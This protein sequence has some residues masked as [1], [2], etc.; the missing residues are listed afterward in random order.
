MTSENKRPS[1]AW[2]KIVKMPKSKII[3]KD[4]LRKMNI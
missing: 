2:L 4:G 3:L 1:Y